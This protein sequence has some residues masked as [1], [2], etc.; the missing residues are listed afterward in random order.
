MTVTVNIALPVQPKRCSFFTLL[1]LGHYGDFLYRDYLVT[2]AYL[3]A[4]HRL[5]VPS[6]A[7]KIAHTVYE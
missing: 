7:E 1:Q 6:R 2:A 3:V 4:T 5:P